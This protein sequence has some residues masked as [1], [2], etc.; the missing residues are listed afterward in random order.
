MLPT[1]P[2]AGD[3]L[4]QARA[5]TAIGSSPVG[6]AVQDSA[7]YQRLGDI[8]EE[9]VAYPAS[10]G[11]LGWWF[12]DREIVIQ[13]VANTTLNGSI[14]AG[15]SSLTLT[16]VTNWDSPSAGN[17]NW[18]LP[19]GQVG[20]GYIK[21]GKSMFDFFTYE[22]LS[23]QT[24]GTVAG[25]SQSH[26][27][28]EQVHKAYLL[29][30]DFGWSRALYKQSVYL[31]YHKMDHALRQVP[32]HPFYTLKYLRGTNYS[33]RFLV[34]PVSIGAMDWNLQYQKAPLNLDSVADDEKADT[35]L[36]LPLGHGRRFYIEKMKAYM[37]EFMG[38]DDDKKMAEDKALFHIN[39]LLD[40][41][42]IE[43]M[44]GDA[45]GIVLADW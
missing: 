3:I 27:T 30:S 45:P 21:N 28:L 7:L 44:S 1:F 32:A 29:P 24:L 26:S 18:I 43:E 40:E 16:S 2:A 14:S 35:T 12:L 37:Y 36:D 6:T 11:V 17:T 23:G 9:G 33:G 4:T 20:A 34:F 42:G 10:V 41:Y 22:S 15:A 25:V 8:N 39:A 5:E 31:K 13:T 38:E 19:P